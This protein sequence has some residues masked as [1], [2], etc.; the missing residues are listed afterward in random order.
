MRNSRS[1]I[2]TKHR[3]AKAYIHVLNPIAILLLNPLYNFPNPFSKLQKTHRET[4]SFAHLV[5]FSD[6]RT[7][8]TT[9]TCIWC[10]R[11]VYIPNDC[12]YYQAFSYSCLAA[13][14]LRLCSNGLQTVSKAHNALVSPPLGLL[15]NYCRHHTY[16][17]ATPRLLNACI[18]SWGKCWY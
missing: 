2:E 4:F 14:K 11:I 18:T 7:S 12:I 8:K 5:S 13:Y 1:S 15:F 10:K 6:K 3:S 16:S 17:H 9:C